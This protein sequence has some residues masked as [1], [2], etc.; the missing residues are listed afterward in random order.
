MSN[1]QIRRIVSDNEDDF[2]LVQLFHNVNN[3]VFK[4]TVS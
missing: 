3:P 2:G 4:M 1:A